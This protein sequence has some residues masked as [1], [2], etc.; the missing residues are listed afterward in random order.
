M[1]WRPER[2]A[3]LRTAALANNSTITDVSF[4][5]VNEL[6]FLDAQDPNISVGRDDHA[7]HQPEPPI[8]RY[9]LGR[10]QR[11]AV[12][13]E[14]GDRLAA[15]AGEPGIVVGVNRQTEGT[16]FHSTAG[17]ASG[18]RRQRSPIRR[19]LARM[20]LP[21]RVLSLP[22]NTEVVAAP[23]VALAVE[24]G[25]AARTEAAAVE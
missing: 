1:K 17:E 9:S 21:Q 6:A 4:R 23:E 8:E 19:K 18:Y 14:H 5:E 15:V 10:R 2:F 13:V 25:L 11:L 3:W 22:T 20:A 16:P 24:H 12:F 7:L